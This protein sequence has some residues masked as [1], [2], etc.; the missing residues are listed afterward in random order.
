MSNKNEEK[1]VSP[2]YEDMYLAIL[3]VFFDLD[4]FG[5]CIKE[6]AMDV[7]GI[8]DLLENAARAVVVE[9]SIIFEGIPGI[10]LLTED[11]RKE[12]I[13]CLVKNSAENTYRDF[14]LHLK[15]H[16]INLLKT[17][18]ERMPEIIEDWV[19]EILRGWETGPS[20]VCLDTFE[21]IEKSVSGE[22]AE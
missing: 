3:T 17:E 12:F 4:E 10:Y 21:S 1:E 16:A 15:F 11:K 2:R 5:E 8:E 22:K 19:P 7:L 18:I 6:A 9:D 14:L 13:N 20:G